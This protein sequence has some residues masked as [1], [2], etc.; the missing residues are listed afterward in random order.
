MRCINFMKQQNKNH[1][2][3]INKYLPTNTCL[4]LN[5]AHLTTSIARRQ[6]THDRRMFEKLPSFLIVRL[7]YSSLHI[8]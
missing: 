2:T 4:L 8:S 3:T 1:T 5:E 7:H 6:N